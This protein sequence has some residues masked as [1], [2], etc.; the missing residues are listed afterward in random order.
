MV[1]N[2]ELKLGSIGMG[3]VGS[4]SGAREKSCLSHH[5]SLCGSASFE[6]LIFIC[7]HDAAS[8]YPQESMSQFVNS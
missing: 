7:D 3:G 4:G 6:I 5:S 8:P 2:R 1:E